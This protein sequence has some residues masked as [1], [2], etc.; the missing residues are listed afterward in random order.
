M[1]R[2]KLKAQ[3][4]TA[5]AFSPFGMVA[6]RPNR[7]PAARLDELDYWSDIAALTDLG[8]PLSIGFASLKVVP[9]V[10]TSMERHLRTFEVLIPLGGDIVV[11]VAPAEYP[12]EPLRLPDPMRFR[13]FRVRAGQ[14]VIFHAAVWHYAPFAVDRPIGMFVLSR[15]GTASDDAYVVELPPSEQIEVEMVHGGAR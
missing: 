14:A 8:G 15:A 2:M 11:V 10:Q 12:S 13:A 9:M 1:G 4:L 5:E 7:P 3:A 6:D